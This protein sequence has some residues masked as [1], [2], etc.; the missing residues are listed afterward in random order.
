MRQ[1][2]HLGNIKAFTQFSRII[3]L[4]IF[5]DEL[6]ERFHLLL[7]WVQAYNV[8]K[9]E[10]KDIWV[11]LYVIERFREAHKIIS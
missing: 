1:E 4:K 2:G 8:T 9:H 5:N 6:Y 3:L 7:S 11:Y 10:I